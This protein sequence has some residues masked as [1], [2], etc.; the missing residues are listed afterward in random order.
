MPF[1]VRTT[2]GF[3]SRIFST[4]LLTCSSSISCIRAQSASFEISMFV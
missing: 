1:S 2:S 4:M 3:N